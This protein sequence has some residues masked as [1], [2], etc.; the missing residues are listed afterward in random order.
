MEFNKYKER[1]AYHWKEYGS[2]TIYTQHVDYFVELYE[3]YK[4]GDNT[5]DIGA[6][7]GL[8][9]DKIGCVGIDD[10]EL[11]VKLARGNGANVT[12]GSAYNLSGSYDNVLMCDVIEH[13]EFPD[14][15]LEQV[16]RITKDRLFI[17]TPPYNGTI[18][19]KYHYREYT[20]ESLIVLME[21]NGFKAEYLTTIPEYVR[22]YGVF[23]KI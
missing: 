10:N 2:D 21:A 19:D 13:L 11:A 12:L 7:D 4:A 6:G 16:Y 17:V 8:I 15:A 14:K 20:E 22:M 3:M 1:G 5:L 18:R 9:T 23:E